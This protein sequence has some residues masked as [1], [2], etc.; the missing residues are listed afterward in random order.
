MRLG[1][2]LALL[3]L[4]APVST[5]LAQSGK[6]S[7]VVTDASTGDPLPGVNVVLDGTTQGAV[8][9][10]DGFYNIINVRPGTYAV[11]ASFIGYTPV[12]RPDVRVNID[13]TTEL[14]FELSEE[15]VGL[16]E[17]TVL[18]ERPIVQRDISANV[19]NFNAAEIENMPVSGV[20]EVI[21]LQAGIEPGLR[22][23]GG[24]LDEVGFYVDGMS[25]PSGRNQQPFTNVS[26][27]SIAEVQVMTGGF[28]A[29][30]GEA[31]S[32]IIN[33]VTKEGQRD[34]YTADVMLRY[35]GASQKY[36]GQQADSEMS[37][38]NRPFLD[39]AVAIDGTQNWDV[40]TRRNYPQFDGGWAK[41]VAEN[42]KNSDPLD[43]NLTVEDLMAIY[44]FRTR[45]SA[46]VT[47]PD[48]DIDGSIGGP[49]PGIS[50]M[51]GDLR[52]L[53][54]YR[55][56]QEAYAV[57]AERPAYMA[58]TG[59]VKVISDIRP[60][61]K[62]VLNGMLSTEDGMNGSAEGAPVMLRGKMPVY[63]WQGD[64]WYFANHMHEGDIYRLGGRALMDVNRSMFGG[65]FTHTLSASSFY[66][67][68]LQRQ[69]TDYFTRPGFDLAK[70]EIV[71]YVQNGQVITDPSDPNWGQGYPLNA[72]P[73]GYDQEHGQQDA[74]G[75][76]WLGG[77]TPSRDTS[78]VTVWSG[79]FDLTS[80][81]N[82]YMQVKTGVDI[83]YSDYDVNHGLEDPYHPH[84]ENPKFVWNR[85]PM[86]AAAYGQTKLEFRGM[87][88]NLGLRLDYF[89]AAGDWYLYDPFDLTLA[90]Y[91]KEVLDAKLEKAPTDRLLTPSPRLGVS[92][93]I[94]DDSKFYFNYGH[95]RQTL[96]PRD[97]FVVRE[98]FGGRIR[99]LGNPNHPMEKTVSYELGYEHN[100]FNR[101]LLRAAG[102]YKDVSDKG[103]EVWFTNLDGQVN[104]RVKYPLNYEDI[105]GVEVTLQKNRGKYV[106]GFVNYT[107]MVRKSG[108][109]GYN[110]QLEN[111]V[112]QKRREDTYRN[113][114]F[115][116]VPEPYARFN[117]EFLAPAGF[118]PEV[119]GAHPL[120]DWRIS[121]LGDWRAGY[122]FTYTGGAEAPG[123]RDNMQWRDFYNLDMRLSKNFGTRLGDAQFF[124]DI[125]NVL[126]LKRM[127][128]HWRTFS[129]G[130]GYGFQRYMQSLHLP[131]EVY[132]DR[133]GELIE[134]INFIPGEDRPGDYRP[135][136][137]EFVPIEIVQD[138]SAVGT[139]HDRP[140]YY[141]KSDG[142]YYRWD[143]AA[144]QAADRSF[145][146]RV[147]EEKAYIDNPPQLWR[148]F[149]NPRDVF[150]G[151]RLTF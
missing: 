148:A 70:D 82:R 49:V 87:V 135:L 122:R 13:L 54:S 78:D 24:N 28:N 62:L 18:A 126:N 138:V 134:G 141:Q 48:Y 136:D 80:Q 74:T 125:S 115:R 96:D 133:K 88:A 63:P 121:F 56:N 104:Y 99:E 27:T 102:Y 106:R 140:L 31:R 72:A 93:P 101:V 83:Q 57:P 146:D 119:A 36:F 145:V 124:V 142:Q 114:L 4:L 76:R 42:Q 117:V 130:D 37:Y 90:S 45:R 35:S 112:E 20:T 11:R 43:D 81:V 9:N 17:V 150:F 68:R 111:L 89:H 103:R 84:H 66:E 75:G 10:V 77:G 64:D 55:Q 97:L 105:R 120:A 3:L 19:A 123:V 59:Q 52:F 23:R 47:R 38:F 2:L 92:F 67:V 108:A 29:E 127:N 132:E 32:G 91:G 5:V 44:K 147:L 118:G 6:I 22:I 16:D 137:V 60:G 7:G 79:A 21:D 40:Y 51:L 129:G 71:A 53:A 113:Y 73:W 46:E 128:N 98:S 14:N 39:P 33:V 26:F 50:R 41:Q 110:F 85:Q 100:L 95:F 149:L 107:Y 131:E 1:K 139:P 12:V 86:K 151:L 25:T 109:F 15:A 69:Y 61:M 30:Y 58:R 143:G 144:W 65:E 116:P 8:T 94:T 34:R